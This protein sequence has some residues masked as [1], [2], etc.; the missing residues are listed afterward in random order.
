MSPSKRAEAL[1]QSGR[2]L[3]ESL[4]PDE[5]RITKR[6]RLKAKL[7]LSTG[8]DPEKNLVSYEFVHEQ[9]ASWLSLL[10]H[11]YSVEDRASSRPRPPPPMKYW[12]TWPDPWMGL[13]EKEGTPNFVSEKFI[14]A[15][16]VSI[17]FVEW[18]WDSLPGK[19]IRPMAS[20][21]L[22]TLVVMATRLGMTWR[23]DIE[24]DTYHATGNGYSLSCT[25]V[26]EM[27]LVA[28]FTAEDKDDRVFHSTLAFN[29]TTDMFMCG[30]I[31]G[32][33]FLV[34]TNIYCT[35]DS[36][37]TNI[38]ENV[39]P[40]IDKRG[41]LRGKLQLSKTPDTHHARG[42]DM[43]ANEVVGLLCEFLPHQGANGHVFAGWKEGP[44]GLS[45][46]PLSSPEGLAV[47]MEP[48]QFQGDVW[49]QLTRLQQYVTSDEDCGEEMTQYCYRTYKRTTLWLHSRGFHNIYNGQ[50]L[51][52][53]LGEKKEGDPS[54]ADGGRE[55]SHANDDGQETAGRFQRSVLVDTHSFSWDGDDPPGYIE[56]EVWTLQYKN[57]VW[58]GALSEYLDEV[59]P[60]NWEASCPKPFLTGWRRKA[61]YQ[62]AWNVM[63]L[64]GM[65]WFWSTKRIGKRAGEEAIPSSCWDNQ[66]PVWII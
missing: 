1:F 19:A 2:I 65:A 49:K 21:N 16:G 50:T 52:M 55:G 58:G 33:S 34:D 30:V 63:M 26:P 15:T 59:L 5:V 38:W 39:L 3:D 25:Q 66:R 9:R 54:Q 35:G 6:A 28:S 8:H 36:R 27:G 41:V 46:C 42:M 10:R 53:H 29:N 23:I 12:G 18:T 43:L 20:T 56:L 7:G 4:M 47:L 40:A 57:Q 62:E 17:S 60:N 14:Y 32:N 48:P 44:R 61:F 51:Y 24:K 11:L 37:E 22:G 64:R 13:L 31:P 45:S